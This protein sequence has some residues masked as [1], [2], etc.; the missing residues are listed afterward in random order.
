MTRNRAALALDLAVKAALVGLLL[1]AVARPDLPQFAG[2][3]IVD[4]A[5][6]YPLATVIVPV[7]WWLVQRRRRRPVA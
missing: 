2:K 7:A 4:R 5:V 1:F 3:G 6:A